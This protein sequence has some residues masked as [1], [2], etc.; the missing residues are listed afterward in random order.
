M[1]TPFIWRPPVA[2]GIPETAAGHLSG[3]CDK[4]RHC[5]VLGMFDVHAMMRLSRVLDVVASSCGAWVAATVSRLGA[6][7]SGKMISD[8]W[9]VEV[10]TG[11]IHRLTAGEHNDTQPRFRR[12]DGALLFLSDRPR[13]GATKEDGTFTQIWLLPTLGGDA[14]ALTDEPL[15]VSRFELSDSGRILALA[16]S[17][18]GAADP[19]A[20]HLKRKKVGPTALSYTDVSVRYWN[21]WLGPEE[22]HLILL[23]GATRLDLTPDAGRSLHD[24]DIAISAN[25]QVAAALWTTGANPDDFVPDTCIRRFDLAAGTATL[26]ASVPRVTH[27]QVRLN[28]DG[29]RIGTSRSQP[30]MMARFGRPVVGYY[31]TA[32]TFHPLCEGTDHWGSP[33]CWVGEGDTASLIC[34]A[35][36]DGHMRLLQYVPGADEAAELTVAGTFSNAS[37]MA[38]GRLLALQSRWFRPAEPVAVSISDGQVQQLA[39]LSGFDVQERLTESCTLEDLRIESSVDGTPIQSWV[40]RPDAETAD[41]SVLLWIHGGPFSAWTDGWHWRWNIAVA[42]STGATVVLPNPGGSTGFGQPFAERVWQKWGGDCFQDI[43]DV[44]DHV[45][46][47]PRIEAERMVAMGGSFGGYMANWVGVQTQR[48]AG[49]ITHASIFDFAA[50]LGPTDEPGW[51]LLEVGEADPYREAEA[52]NEWSPHRLVHQWKTPALIIHGEKDYR[53]PISESLALFGALKRQQVDAELLVFPDEGH[54]IARPNNVVAWYEA[55]FEFIRRRT[56]ADPA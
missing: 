40:L 11:A 24:T 53:C 21:R 16:D 29:S 33:M 43:M 45:A 23:D 41:G 55:V 13:P 56:A 44:V 32:A 5:M 35:P 7:D 49:I 54:W 48:F 39:S 47:D 9:R 17:L 22:A 36:V 3:W 18:P 8:L 51:W 26:V 46:E 38:D 12:E 30:R 28:A 37:V 19:R 42:V 14:R 2:R 25:G 20:T 31:D 10:A 1:T 50:M 6:N 4:T 34:T 27:G 15:G 52:F